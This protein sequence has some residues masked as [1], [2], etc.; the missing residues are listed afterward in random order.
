MLVRYPMLHC[1]LSAYLP[2]ATACRRTPMLERMLPKRVAVVLL[3]PLLVQK[4][5][6]EW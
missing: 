1:V 3:P 6:E 4:P 5:Q 2:Q